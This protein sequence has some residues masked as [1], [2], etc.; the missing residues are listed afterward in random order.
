MFLS[1]FSS[2]IE[3]LTTAPGYLLIAGDFNFHIDDVTNREASYF[4]ELLESS[5]LQQHTTETTHR[6]GHTLDLIISRQTDNLV[7]STTIHRG[8]PSDHDAVS[9]NL[10][11]PRV[12]STRRKVCYRNFKSIN[13]AEMRKDIQASPLVTSHTSDLTTIINQYNTTL[14]Q[15]INHHAPEK[16]RTI[17]LRPHAPWYSD[18][19]HAAKQKKRQLE[20]K[21]MSSGLEIDKQIF[22]EECKAYHHMIESAKSTY[23]SDR[24]A[25]CDQKKLFKIIDK[26]LTPED[27]NTLPASDCP[28]KLANKFANYF[29]SKINS[30]REDLDELVVP[31]VNT[32]NSHTPIAKRLSEFSPVSS[33]LVRKII[34]DS[35]NKHCQLDPLP[36]WMLKECIDELL[37]SIM[38]IINASL[39]S[40]CVPNSFKTALITPIIKNLK[41]DPNDLKNY[42]PISNLP[43]LSKVLEK[44]V[45]H[46]L[47]HHLQSNDL[48]AKMQSAYRKH[49]ST[50]TAII[51]VYNDILHAIDGHQDVILVL[52]DL[53][54]AFDTI[55]HQILI[56]RMHKR[57]GI[58]GTVLSWFRSYLQ[59]RTQHVTVNNAKSACHSLNFGVPQG[60]VLGPIL[61]TMYV[62]PLEDLIS[63]HNLNSMMYADDSQ[64]YQM[65]K[66]SQHMN[67]VSRIE[68]CIAD[69]RTWYALNKLKQNRDNPLLISIQ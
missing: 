7:S 61:F 65:M 28:E 35:P 37:P 16:T 20:R 47:H 62:A 39:A 29:D 13:M 46:E 68:A 14:H 25:N 63:Q 51:R 48:Y 49:H 67:T 57:F 42:R 38:E 23:H 12:K 41:N 11:V 52:L 9:C 32:V 2:L 30:L 6:C 3:T 56:D 36:T 27:D 26:M 55:D 44:V 31:T 64:L 1:Q 24:I 19:I 21:W 33:E 69:I 22:K 58:D 17:T 45:A 40:G 15:Y 53:S 59:H 43:F 60:S 54:A 18:V 66:R 34:M 50:E 10:A 8:L 4:L 5:N